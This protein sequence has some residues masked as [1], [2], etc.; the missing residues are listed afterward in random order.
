MIL[1]MHHTGFVVADLERAVEFYEGGVGLEVQN[2]YERQGGPIEQVVGY[3]DAH[4]KIAI[5]GIGGEHVLELIQYV[6]PAPGQRPTSERSV[7][8]GSHLAFAVDDIQATYKNL[9]GA[10]ART[11][12][13][14]ISVA[15]GRTVC[16]LQDP[17]GNWLELM[18]LK[19]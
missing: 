1:K 2:R 7:I 5:L 14:P 13:A 15:P 18:E 9:S 17:D 16:Y 11:L 3:T 4:L 6:N 10:G 19:E 12:N 8:G